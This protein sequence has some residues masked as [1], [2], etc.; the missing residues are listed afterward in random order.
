LGSANSP[1][2][3]FN[4]ISGSATLDITAAMDP[5][6]LTLTTN[7]TIQVEGVTAILSTPPAGTGTLSKTGTGILVIP[8]NLHSST[9]P[10]SV[11]AGTLQV[12][13]G[14]ALP[15]AATSVAS[16]A[17]LELIGPGS[18]DYVQAGTVPGVTTILSGGILQVGSGVSAA[19]NGDAFSGTLLFSSG[20]IL[21][22]GGPWA[23]D[24]TVGTPL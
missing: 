24:I 20:S 7:G 3:T 8:S 22:L 5:G 10:L 12:S 4:A 9:T 18:N 11:L 19:G 6:T 2:V 15:T 21:N 14:G 13:S 16:G 17:I 1:A 23:R